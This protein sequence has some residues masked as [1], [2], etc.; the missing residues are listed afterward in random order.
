MGGKP[1]AHTYTVETS[2]ETEI[3]VRKMKFVFFFR[4]AIWFPTEQFQISYTA[5]TA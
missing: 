1:Y 4:F 3:L 5:Y 2:D